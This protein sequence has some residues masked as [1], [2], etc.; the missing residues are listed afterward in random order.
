LESIAERVFRA[1]GKSIVE[2]V[3]R[4]HVESIVESVFRTHV[5]PDV[6]ATL[7]VARLRAPAR[8]P[9]PRCAFKNAHECG[10]NNRAKN[11]QPCGIRVRNHGS[12]VRPA[13]NTG[14]PTG[15]PYMLRF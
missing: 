14:D 5:K 12:I 11:E 3:F 4:D 6:G 15:R 7:A 1:R 8:S 10:M 9:H 2:S 13:H